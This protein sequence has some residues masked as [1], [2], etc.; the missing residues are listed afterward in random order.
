MPPRQIPEV[1]QVVE[2]RYLYA[3]R[4]S[5]ALYQ[6]VYLG[7]RHDVDSSECLLTR[8]KRD[9]RTG[10]V[11]FQRT[12]SDVKYATVFFVDDVRGSIGADGKRDAFR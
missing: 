7:P 1:C 3:H 9:A 10:K 5:H 4:E 2:V 11:A 6:P 12:A 8:H